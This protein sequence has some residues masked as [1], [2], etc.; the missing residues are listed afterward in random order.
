MG[1]G[2][3][4]LVMVSCLV[5]ATHIQAVSL[6]IRT[7]AKLGKSIP[8]VFH[9]YLHDRHVCIGDLMHNQFGAW[10]IYSSIGISGRTPHASTKNTLLDHS[11]LLPGFTTFNHSGYVSRGLGENCHNQ[12]KTAAFAKS[13]EQASRLGSHQNTYLNPPK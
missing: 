11:S 9:L 2:G 3:I 12:I 5:V 7:P 13:V 1:K 4:L 6:R 8:T 10:G